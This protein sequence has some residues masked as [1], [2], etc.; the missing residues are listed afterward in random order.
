V[1]VAGEP[2]EAVLE[3]ARAGAGWAWERI[4]DGLAPKVL[5]YLRA[6]G[7]AD[8]D[9]I[10]GDVFC[11]LVRDIHGFQGDEAGFRSWVFVMAHRRFIDDIRRRQR[12]PEALAGPDAFG[13]LQDPSDV[14][15]DVVRGD[16]EALI[17]RLIEGLTAPQ[18]DVLL[19]R[20]FGG[21]TVEEVAK[22]VGRRPGAVKALQRRGLEV[23]RRRLDEHGDVPF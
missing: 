18:R 10:C 7:A 20:I 1:T 4:Y 3:A 21:L 6:R 23:L 9:G 15:G 2:F 11:Q 8:P 14:E 13:A 19:L 16:R 12:R 17:R 5:G 22:A